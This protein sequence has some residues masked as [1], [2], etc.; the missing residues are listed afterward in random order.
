M[1]KPS[2]KHL[3]FICSIILLSLLIILFYQVR[4]ER[5]LGDYYYTMAEVD[6]DIN[7]AVYSGALYKLEEAYNEIFNPKTAL[8]FL[9]RAERL[10]RETNSYDFFS[11][12]SIEIYIRYGRNTEIAAIAGYATQ[13]Y[14]E[15][16]K[17]I[18]ISQK[19]LKS[20]NFS[21]LHLLNVIKY[22]SDKIRSD[23]DEKS[24]KGYAFL[25]DDKEITPDVLLD[26]ASFFGDQKYLLDAALMTLSAGNIDDAWEIL[27]DSGKDGSLDEIKSFI[28]YDRQD[29][30]T[31]KVYLNRLSMRTG[32][33]ELILFKGDVLLRNSSYDQA[34]LVYEDFIKKYP[35]YSSIPYRNLYSINYTYSIRNTWLAEG[36]NYFPEARDLLLT[37]AWELYKEGDLQGTADVLKKVESNDSS[38]E[39][40]KLN[41][42][43]TGRSPEHIIGKYWT[44]YNA[45][46][47]DE[48]TAVSF[49][50]FLLKN[51]QY[52]QLDILL[53]RYVEAADVEDWVYSYSAISMALQ[54][55]YGEAAREIR[56]A[57]DISVNV[58]NYYNMGEILSLGKKYDEAVDALQKA[59]VENDTGVRNDEYAGKIYY[60]LAEIH[61]N[62]ND[63]V[64][65]E[66]YLHKLMAINPNDMK[67][68]LLMKKIQERY[69]D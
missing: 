64:L 6:S 53:Q 24:S 23:I 61:Y 7:S 54:G 2:I 55:R 43:L 50:N 31:A 63:Y 17:S 18:E 39:L 29:Y 45:A 66:D 49:S 35:L 57:L 47:D 34:N 33:P 58:P 19:K 59:L 11:K 1:N 67:S 26:A 8:M 46:P 14:E 48:S 69:Y 3:I 65:A 22:K 20:S 5:R 25:F 56:K 32:N 52:E 12:Y 44:I 60:K 38:L 30:R 15:Y 10:A 9:K 13:K 62:I 16:D 4:N 27:G 21:E 28:A 41:M 36:L 51:R 40:F 42:M 68:S 37:F